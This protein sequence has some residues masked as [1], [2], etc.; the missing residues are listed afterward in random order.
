MDYD[1]VVVGGGP[2]GVSTAYTLAKLNKKVLLLDKKNLLQIGNKSCGDALDMSSPQMLHDEFGLAMPHDAE[3][4]ESL[5]FLTVATPHTHLSLDAPGYTVDR[6]IYGQRLLQECENAGVTVIAS[7]PVRGVIIE[8]NYV[9]GVHYFHNGKEHTVR[10]KLTIDC[11]GIIGAVR[12]TLP[13]GFSLGLH[14]KIPSHHIAASYREIVELKENHPWPNEI[15]LL[16]EPILPPP[17]YLWF[18]SKGERKLNLGTGWLKSDNDK[19]S[20]SMKEIYREALRKHYADDEYTI[21]QKGG[22]Q[23]P[24]RPPFDSLT[25]NGGMVVGDAGAMV[26]PT[27]AEGHGPALV[28]GLYAGKTAATALDSGNVSREGM[29]EYNTKVMHHYGERNSVSYV[30]LQYLR[31]LGA[32]GMD[33][34]LNRGILTQEELTAVYGGEDLHLSISSVLK[35][36]IL[37][38]PRF[39]YLLTLYKLAKDVKQIGQHYLQYPS[40]PADLP[41]W[42]EQRNALLKES[43]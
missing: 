7:A 34:F 41:A 42:I 38:F 29:W 26:D 14:P 27:T 4:T 2:A 3:V 17:G 33:F 19:L 15:V 37:A 32:S 12:K 10:A 28:S 5:K 6:H 36:I 21:L 43:L 16:Y 23:I 22:G 1:V 20:R 9:V 18:F 30:A 8:D 35:K 31:K 11:S 40:N 39:D 24:I 25:F 13:E